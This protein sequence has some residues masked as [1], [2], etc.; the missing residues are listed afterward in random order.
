MLILVPGHKEVG[1]VKRK[2][3]VKQSIKN[4]FVINQNLSAAH[5]SDTDIKSRS[6]AEVMNEE[7]NGVRLPSYNIMCI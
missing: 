5:S 1:E 4:N 7:K 2:I 6:S 3:L